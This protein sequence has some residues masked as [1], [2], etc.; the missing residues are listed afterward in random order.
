[1]I[2]KVNLSTI[3]KRVVANRFSAWLA[4]WLGLSAFTWHFDHINIRQ[5]MTPDSLINQLYH[6]GSEYISLKTVIL[7]LSHVTPR[8]IFYHLVFSAIIA[9]FGVSIYIIAKEKYSTRV[10]TLSSMI[11]MAQAY[12]LL[13]VGGMDFSL[14]SLVALPIIILLC[15][16]LHPKHS[17]TNFLLLGL[18]IAIL[19]SVPYFWL[20]LVLG[21]VLAKTR[22]RTLFKHIT[23]LKKAYLI[24]P[25]VVTIGLASF[26]TFKRNDYGWLV[27]KISDTNTELSAIF[28]SLKEVVKRLLIDYDL[29]TSEK[30]PLISVALLI[31]AA[32]STYMYIQGFS[33]IQQK[34]IP[35]ICVGA[36]IATVSGV[37]SLY[38]V[39]LSGIVVM[40]VNGLA[41][42]LQQWFTVF[43]KNPFARSSAII[44]I[45][46]V[47]SVM[48][49][50]QIVSYIELTKLV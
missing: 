33:S 25:S 30:L 42:L 9:V 23:R 38:F 41:M 5:V 44:L 11:A 6:G 50:T 3:W 46:A 29:T 47:I 36:F 48:V 35:T 13:A 22:L 40:S 43:P 26:Y 12:I 7:G 8:G 16:W 18:T 27:G 1:M 17:A 28:A 4:T 24:L 32:L 45:V 10:A 39:I 20:M 15:S 31:L 34:I 2:K 19:M 37:V 49:M 21:I 14:L